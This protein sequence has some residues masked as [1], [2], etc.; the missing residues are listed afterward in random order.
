MPELALHVAEVAAA[1]EE[2]LEHQRLLAGEAGEP[3]DPELALDDGPAVAAPEARDREL[4][5]ADGAGGDD[6]MRHG[7]FLVMC[8][9][10]FLF[11]NIDFPYCQVHMCVGSV[12]ASAA[13]HC[14][15]C[16]SPRRSSSRGA[17]PR[18]SGSRPRSSRRSARARSGPAVTVTINGY[19]Y[20]STIAAYGDVFML[21]LAAEN[22]AGAGVE[23][24]DEVEVDLDLDTAPR[25]VEVPPDLAAAL[26]DEPE[27]RAFFDG[28]SYSNRRSF[29]LNV[30]GTKNEETRRR[31]VGQG[32]RDAPAGASLDRC[33]GPGRATG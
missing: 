20:R 8:E 23:A 5:R 30:E 25:E 33:A 11:S 27:A 26:V 32:A 22:R 17:R 18:G 10:V 6:V 3:S 7:S 28:L 14:P 15:A 4:A 21:P 12:D 1:A 31:R 9:C 16:D 2:A 13:L 29:V 24:G 19:T